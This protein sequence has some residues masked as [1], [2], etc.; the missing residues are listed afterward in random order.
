MKILKTFLAVALS[1]CIITVNAETLVVFGQNDTA[2]VSWDWPTTRM[3]GDALSPEEISHIELEINEGRQ[4]KSV[5]IPHPTPSYAYTI[6]QTGLV[7]FKAATVDTN[8]IKSPF[9][10]PLCAVIV[11]PPA[12]I[13]IRFQ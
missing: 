10:E 2:T 3:N 9:T 8:S 13:Q 7:C 12:V 5:T 1:A 4:S 11:S 6:E